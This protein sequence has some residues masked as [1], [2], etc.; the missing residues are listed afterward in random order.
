MR[1]FIIVIVAIGLFYA[2]SF[3]D[4]TFS[5]QTITDPAYYTNRFFSIFVNSND[6]QTIRKLVVT[7]MHEMRVYQ[8]VNEQ[9]FILLV[10]NNLNSL[11]KRYISGTVSMINR[12]EKL[13]WVVVNIIEQDGLK[14][15][16]LGV[17]Y[18]T[19]EE[20]AKYDFSANLTKCRTN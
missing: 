1:V 20:I 8:D 15:V 3:T 19:C 10:D 12:P 7:Q 2:P 14:L 11:G 17:T 9:D 13:R 4:K 16:S 18:P 6:R 5:L